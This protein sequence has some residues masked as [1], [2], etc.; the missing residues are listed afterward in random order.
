MKWLAPIVVGIAALGGG[1]GFGLIMG[2]DPSD[3]NLVR[4]NPYAVLVAVAVY[5]IFFMAI[6]G[7]VAGNLRRLA[8]SARAREWQT[9]RALGRTLRSIVASE[10][11]LGLR[12]GAIVSGTLLVAGAASRQFLPWSDGQAYLSGGH[13][14]PS[15]FAGLALVLV[16]C[17]GTTVAVYVIAALTAVGAAGGPGAVPSSVRPSRAPGRW[18]R[19]VF[20]VTAGAYALSTLALLWRRVVPIRWDLA[21][22]QS[23]GAY[24][25]SWVSLAG[26]VFTL[27]SVVVV[28]GAISALAG[29]ISRVAGRVLMS[30][31]R[32]VFLQAGDALARPSTERHIALGTMAIVLGLVTWISAASDISATRNHLADQFAPLAVVTPSALSDQGTQA[33]AP[34]EGY[35]AETLPQNVVAKLTTDKRLVTIP[36][37]YLRAE[38]RGVENSPAVLCGGEPCDR[39]TWREDTYVVVA[40]DAVARLSPDGLRPFGFAAG[41]TLQG[42]GP[43]LMSAPGSPGPTWLTVDGEKYRIYRSD[44]NAAANFIDAAW[45]RSRFGELPVTGVWINLAH[46]EGLTD[47]QRLDTIDG[48][49]DD[50]IGGDPTVGRLTFSYGYDGTSN[51]GGGSLGGIAAAGLGL[52]LSVALIGGLA[53]RSARDR[54]RDLATMAALGASPRTLRMAPVAEMLVTTL[55]AAVAGVGAGLVLA[56]LSTHPTLFAPGA[57]LA[58]GNTLWLVRWN[59]AQISWG[60]IGAA[61]LAAVLLTTAVAAVYAVSMA[62]RTPVDE[63][64]EALKEGA[65]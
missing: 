7:L 16:V 25:Y 35:P 60:P 9:E 55:S 15:A 1:Y 18:G 44:L 32:G 45:A 10:A 42:T 54:R 26:V 65:L 51:S 19:V 46:P 4:G 23:G 37:A 62:R 43:T 61:V 38:A 14:Q 31:G 47:Q 49:L 33:T 5:G 53:A 21:E 39:R 13:F 8:I 6:L 29:L 36:F 20:L 50:T 11:R 28:T 48:I 12:H 57:P 22:T 27:G 24:D 64:R 52:L 17:V 63:L 30:R 40:A 56:I 3:P 34:P 59:A 58:L 41:V 2:P